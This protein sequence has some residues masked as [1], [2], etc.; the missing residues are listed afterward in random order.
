MIT[1]MAVPTIRPETMATHMERRK[2]SGASG[3][4][5]RP[6]ARAQTTTGR[7]RDLAAWTM[8]S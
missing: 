2:I 1:V 5:P 6:V 8:A 3:M 7:A 4:S